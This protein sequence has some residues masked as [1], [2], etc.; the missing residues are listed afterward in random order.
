MNVGDLIHSDNA[1]E[2]VYIAGNLAGYPDVVVKTTNEIV[3]SA[4]HSWEHDTPKSQLKKI[5]CRIYIALRNK[6]ID[7]IYR[8]QGE[9]WQNFCDDIVLY[10]TLMLVLKM[11]KYIPL[12]L[13]DE[14]PNL[15]IQ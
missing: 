14:E 4:I 10:Y 7:K 13:T 1:P 8:E 5:L 6:D 2:F 12:V 11:I 3:L 9:E 15:P